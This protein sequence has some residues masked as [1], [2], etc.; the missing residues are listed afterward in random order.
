MQDF[1]LINTIF[2]VLV[3][4]FSVVIHEISHGVAADKLGDPTARMQG[5]ITLNPIPHIDPLGSIILPFIL[6]I[7]GSPFIVG[8]AKPVPFN[9]YN[10]RQSRLIQKFGEAFVAI[11]GPASNIFIAIVFGLALRFLEPLGLLNDPA[12]SIMNIIVLVNLILAV[13]NLIPVPPLDG[14]KILFSFLPY[15]YRGIR[16]FL[17]TYAI[18][19]AL[20]VIIFLWRFILP[21]VFFLYRLILGN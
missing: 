3:L 11:A 8:W 21:V 2:Y 20:F 16:V 4:I 9:P 18:F 17:E 19:I 15:Q 7:T 1:S 10:F 14:S 13:F 6:V 12:I 5:R